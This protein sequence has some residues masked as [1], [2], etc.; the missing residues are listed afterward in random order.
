MCVSEFVSLNF[1]P[2]LEQILPIVTRVYKILHQQFI[3]VYSI[4]VTQ[5]AHASIFD[6]AKYEAGLEVGN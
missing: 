6:I 4:H 1:I 2:N 3:H 5:H